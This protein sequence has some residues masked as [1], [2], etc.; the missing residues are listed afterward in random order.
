MSTSAEELESTDVAGGG[1]SQLSATDTAVTTMFTLSAKRLGL[2][3]NVAVLLALPILLLL[4]NNSWSSGWVETPP[5]SAWVE[6]GNK[7][8]S[9][10]TGWLVNYSAKSLDTPIGWV[11]PY[12]YQ[13][14]F[15]DLK[16]TLRHQKEQYQMSSYYP[17]RLPWLLLGSAVYS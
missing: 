4:I 12:I 15:L 6:A 7:R 10:P 13:S 14:F 5:G 3:W 1:Q 9:P 17:S 8:T 2:R 16:G 11:D